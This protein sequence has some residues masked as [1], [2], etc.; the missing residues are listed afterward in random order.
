[1][2]DKVRDIN[3]TR[4]AANNTIITASHLKESSQRD[5]NHTMEECAKAIFLWGE[6]GL[7]TSFYSE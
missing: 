7:C 4:G 5:L 2:C 3:L 6:G 1:M